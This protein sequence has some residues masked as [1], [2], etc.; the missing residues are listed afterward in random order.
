MKRIF[1]AKLA[2]LAAILAALQ[3]AFGVASGYKD[4]P[5]PVR[6]C[7]AYLE[8]G[9]DVIYLG[10]STLYTFDPADKDQAPINEMLQRLLP[11]LRIGCVAHDA[12][13]MELYD[14]FATYLAGKPHP[15]RLVIV[16][17][18]LGTVSPYWD[19]RPEYQFERLKLFL[20]HDNALFR[21]FYR[22]LAVFHVLNLTP[23]SQREFD[24]TLVYDG[25]T[26]V[27]LMS[28]FTSPAYR[29]FSEQHMRDQ[30]VLRYMYRVP[31]DHPKLLAM[32]RLARTLEKAGVQVLFYLTPIDYE[33]GDQYLG[34]RFSERIR[35]NAALFT[36]K[37]DEAGQKPLDLTFN[38]G[39][40]Q[41]HWGSLY[42]NEHLNESGRRYVAEQLAQTVRARLEAPAK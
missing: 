7:D 22:P 30:L 20:R 17:I 41:F 18:N 38:L 11:E 28:T 27:G 5:T 13:H 19:R 32:T 37:L 36:T 12:Y 39:A 33:T 26:P 40:G 1:I 6:L 16:P 34:P 35:E 10:E 24:H 4:T 9:R 15:P 8:E 3:L 14:A 29:T 21:A 2:L 25:D 23:H 31:P 42:P